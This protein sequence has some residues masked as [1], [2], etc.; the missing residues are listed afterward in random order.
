M[1]QFLLTAA[2]V[3][4]ALIL[5]FV[6]LP[7]VLVVGIIASA[8][9]APTPSRAV[10]S[11]DLR[12]SLP[13][14]EPDNPLAFLTGRKLSVLSVAQ[15][16]R[17]AAADGNVKALLI[18][19]PEGGMAPAA[20]DEIRAAVLAFRAA[21]K[22]VIAHSQGIY[23]SGVPVATYMLGAAS[24]GGFWMQPQ[25]S[26]QATGAASETMFYKRLFDKYGVKA[27]FQQ[28]YQYKTAVNPLLY[29]DYTPAHREEE[30]GWMGSVYGSEIAAAAADRHMAA[31]ELRT[32]LEAGPYI[33]Q[34]AQQR[35][36]VDHV[37]GVEEAEAQLKADAGDGAELV[38]F[39]RYTA[40]AASRTNA[41]ST[42]AIAVIG[43]EGDIVTGTARNTGFSTSTDVRS[44]DLQRAFQ[45]ATADRSVKAIV[46]RVSSPGG[47]DTASEQIGAAV[48]AAKAA[49]K[50][51]VVSMGTYAASGGY[52]ISADA[53]EIVA[54]PTTLTGSIGVFGGKFVLGPAL[55]RFG[56]DTHDLSVGGPYA[57]SF[58]TAAPFTPQQTAAVSAWMDRIYQG[59]VTRVA[60]GRRLPPARVG[61]IARGRVWTGQQAIALGLVD[62]LGGFSSAL[63]EAKR[64]A[65]LRVSDRVQLK[66]ISGEASPFSQIGNVF[67]SGRASLDLLIRAA[68]ITQAPQARNLAVQVDRLRLQ[69]EGKAAVLAA[70]PSF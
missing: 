57:D 60:T 32:A 19:L 53:S 4:V 52:W 46:F 6:G 65:G 13:D 68:Q 14:Q 15:G 22:P 10:L 37:G 59:F 2:G 28:R 67:G 51:V 25:A 1:K 16:L 35:R 38:D 31:A 49:G 44:D 36:L 20:A 29:D 39:N 43:A 27:D 45:K 47:S 64:L 33:A 56:V 30:L 63:A 8:R 12:Q 18:R 9:P 3:F 55:A 40:R 62:R 50:P 21:G 7:L 34:D 58:G 24:G 26:L 66:E 23:P 11:L 17:D 54:Q 61:E 70:L 41:G 48:R 42:D 69:S 5:F